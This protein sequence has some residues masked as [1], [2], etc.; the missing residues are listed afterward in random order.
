[1]SLPAALPRTGE[2]L[3]PT[4]SALRPYVALAAA[5][6]RR[7]STYR[8]AAVAGVFTNTVFGVIKL[9]I[10]LAVAESA[11]GTVAG[12]D[13]ASLSTYTWVSQG[14]IAVVMIF[15]WTE[16]ADRVRTGDIA[17][18]LARPV[19]L[20]LAWLAADLG[21]AAWSLLSRALV[22][23]AFGA[24]VYGL[25]VPSDPTALALLPV[26]LLLAVVVSFGCRF[27]VNLTA[28]W[29]VEVRGVVLLYVLVS[30]VLGGHLVPVHFF[31][32]WLQAVAYATPFPSMVQTPIDL[33]TG[34]AD[35]GAAVGLVL[36]QVAWAAGVLLLGR[37]VLVRA[38]RKLVLQGG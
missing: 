20:Q 11:G 19:D 12:Y 38:T 21:R 36:A 10:L 25:Y 26:S 8:Q 1:V 16:L 35:G 7:W 17:V 23:L 5:G 28:F 22:P 9:S 4:A 14:L 30:G 37:V 2:P 32:G 18:D 3:S 27:V 29:L 31:P 15:S 24:L 6:F 13:A 34:Q 33:V